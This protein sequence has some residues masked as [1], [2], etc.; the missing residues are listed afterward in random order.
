MMTI[1]IIIVIMIIII[2][3]LYHIIIIISI[4]IIMSLIS[5]YYYHNYH[6]YLYHYYHNCYYW[7]YFLAWTSSVTNSQFVDDLRR[8]DDH[9]TSPQEI[10][11]FHWRFMNAAWMNLIPTWIN[12]LLAKK[13]VTPRDDVSFLWLFLFHQ[14]AR[15][16]DRL[17]GVI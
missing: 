15:S 7:Y 5:L 12:T 8:N 13:V 11:I 9:V 4:I 10:G 1:I 3:M 17:F 14:S 6:N 16:K 2:I